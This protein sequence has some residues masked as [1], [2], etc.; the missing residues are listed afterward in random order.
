MTTVPAVWTTL[1][2]HDH[3]AALAFLTSAFGFTERAVHRDGDRLVHAELT[4]TG[5][6]GTSVGGVMF[7]EGGDPK[8]IGHG[9]AHVVTGTPDALF[10]Q[11]VAG[12]ATVV[13]APEDT[14]YG[15]RQFIVL[16]PE[17]NLW[18]FG[19]WYE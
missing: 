13:R 7:G 19:T 9:C 5:P 18:S 4:F 6:D 16:D 11:A 15:S 2:Y 14:E 10:E 1:T 12:G 8:R 3:E 17:D